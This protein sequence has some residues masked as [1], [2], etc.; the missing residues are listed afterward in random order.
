M[1][2]QFILTILTATVLCGM[3]WTYRVFLNP[4]IVPT[5]LSVNKDIPVILPPGETVPKENRDL[6]EKYLTHVPWVQ[7]SA[8]D[9]MDLK[10]KE[11]CFIYTHQWKLEPNNKAV[12][13]KP[14]AMIL[15]GKDNSQEPVTVVSESAYVEF[16]DEFDFSSKNPVRAIKGQLKGEV[17]VR[18]PDGLHMAG[19]TF[20]Y[21][22]DAMTVVCDDSNI[23]FSYAGSSGSASGLVINLE[24]NK[25]VKQTNS[26]SDLEVTSIR[27]RKDV[28]LHYQPEAKPGKKSEDLEPVHLSCNG[29]LSYNLK[30]LT[31]QMI[32]QVRVNRGADPEERLSCICDSVTLNLTDAPIASSPDK[33]NNRLK[34]SKLSAVGSENYPLKLVS[35]KEDMSV[36][37][38]ELI[39]LPINRTAWLRSKKHVQISQKNNLFLCNQLEILHND[40]NKI[41]STT[42]LGEGHYKQLNLATGQTDVEGSWQ[43]RAVYIH[44][45]DTNQEQITLEGRALFHSV[46]ASEVASGEDVQTVDRSRKMSTQADSIEV[47]L[48]REEQN[49]NGKARVQVRPT[50]LVANQNVIMKSNQTGAE[51]DQLL[52]HFQPVVMGA[53]ST[54]A[55]QPDNKSKQLKKPEDALNQLEDPLRVKAKQ[56][57]VWIGQELTAGGKSK[58]VLNQAEVSGNVFVEQ[59]NAKNGSKIHINGNYIQ[60]HNDSQQNQQ[61]VAVFGQPAT[62]Q[63]EQFKMQGNN[64]K[65]DRSK[66]LAWVEGPGRLSLPIKKGEWLAKEDV[67]TIS[68][69]EKMAFQ[70]DKAIFLGIVSAK[71]QT[72][73]NRLDCKEMT[74]D[75]TQPISFTTPD[76][77][78]RPDIKSIFC[79]GNVQI[80]GE[81]YDKDGLSQI[82]DA[83]FY[84]LRIEP[85]SGH[86][87]AQGPGEIE[88]W[89]RHNPDDENKAGLGRKVKA[90]ANRSF[91]SSKM[92]WDYI[93]VRFQ[94]ESIGNIGKQ[95]N[96]FTGGVGIVYGPVEHTQERVDRDHLTE[97]SGWLHSN[98]LV[99]VGHKN[100]KT[101]KT[102]VEIIAEED[103]RIESLKFHATADSITYD[104]SKEGYILRSLGENLVTLYR[105]D[106]VGGTLSPYEAQ[107]IR[108]YPQSGDI[109]RPRLLVHPS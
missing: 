74:V 11:R 56:M 81:E 62:M 42:C 19:R 86:T 67:L 46:A 83:R 17:E 75:F 45:P 104:Q 69:T 97:Y 13:I 63:G 25:A 102:H 29:G 88:V 34:L 61:Q 54:Y 101:K 9:R 73:I 66:N 32:D 24:Q 95:T 71:T 18:G 98:K 109:H 52:V 27:L 12:E 93:N 76:S 14:F 78:K 38:D 21:S 7:D 85:E 16:N 10:W 44:H 106:E 1:G 72:T 35:A 99:I 28:E 92:K 2:R 22:E 82:R 39:Y 30:T 50:K 15:F 91:E 40:E 60:I 33:N 20:V 41:I 70:N 43:D 5:V 4:M 37:A 107:S 23:E 64:F 94:R 48:R 26:V 108:Y 36:D 59:E 89:A 68:W 105:Q 84:T 80:H 103:A 6:A 3:A 49:W 31:V 87:H 47:W 55:D 51:V 53:I 77:K 65:V 57:Q 90:V 100:P 8:S 58:Y 79:Q 96:T